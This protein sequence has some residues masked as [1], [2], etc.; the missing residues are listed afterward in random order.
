[1]ASAIELLREVMN[2][3]STVNALRGDVDQMRI[4]QRE[5]LERIVKLEQRGETMIERAAREA[6][7]IA[8]QSVSRMMAPIFHQVMRAEGPARLEGA[9]S[10]RPP[11][12]DKR[13][14]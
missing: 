2:L 3:T 12:E 6:S 10:P 1:M 7:E 11:L 4:I 14:H 5:Y 9:E 13:P 8:M